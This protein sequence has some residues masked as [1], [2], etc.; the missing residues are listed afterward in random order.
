MEIGS[1]LLSSLLTSSSLDLLSDFLRSLLTP[2]S[3][4]PQHVQNFLTLLLSS[5]LPSPSLLVLLLRLSSKILSDPKILQKKQ[6]FLHWILESGGGWIREEEGVE[7]REEDGRREEE[8]RKAD[9]ERRREVGRREDKRREKEGRREEGRNEEGRRKEELRIKVLLGVFREVSK[10]FGKIYT[11]ENDNMIGLEICEVIFFG[12]SSVN[13]EILKEISS[14]E[15]GLYPQFFENV[16]QMLT[17]IKNEKMNEGREAGGIVGGLGG[18]IGGVI[19]LG[20]GEGGGEGGEVGGLAVGEAGGGGAGESNKMVNIL[21]TEEILNQSG[22]QMLE[23]SEI[24]SVFGAE[25]LFGRER[26]E[27]GN[28]SK[29][30][31]VLDEYSFDEFQGSI[32]KRGI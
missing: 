14:M 5:S 8:R 17:L 26:E 10:S 13:Q 30:M 23:I 21:K 32:I 1:S 4:T 6:N 20:G 22:E 31:N 12:L 27:K 28:R 3:L 18:G 25:G 16:L 2:P 11:I 9:E 29:M 24:S 19:G 15:G 7:R